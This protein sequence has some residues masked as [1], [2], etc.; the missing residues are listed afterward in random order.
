MKRGVFIFLI[1]LLLVLCPIYSTG[2][3]LNKIS[4]EVLEKVSSND[5]VPVVVEIEKKPSFVAQLVSDAK[6]KKEYVSMELDSDEIASLASDPDVARIT[7]DKTYVLQLSQTVPQINASVAHSTVFKNQN[8][9]GISSTVCVIDTGVNSSHESLAG[10][11]VAEYCYCSAG[12]GCCPNGSVE[13]DSARDGHGHGTHVS[14]IVA[15]G[16]NVIG[17]A[18]GANLAVVKVFSDSGSTTSTDIVNAIAWCVDHASQY[19]ITAISMS[20]G[21]TTQYS[22]YCDSTSPFTSEINRAIANNITVV[23]STGNDYN[24]TGISDPA[25]VQN[26]TA[27]SSV[28]KSD[29]FPGYANRNQL[30]DLVAPG[31]DSSNPVVST[32]YTGGTTS[33]YGTSMAAPHV[34]GAIAILSQYKRLEGS[35]ATPYEMQSYLYDSGLSLHDSSSNRTY[36]RIDVYAA[37]LEA[38]ETNPDLYGADYSPHQVLPDS[39]LTLYINASDNLRLSSVWVEGNFSGNFSNYSMSN[40]AG[41]LYSVTIYSGNFSAGQNLTWRFFTNDSNG[42]LNTTQYY[43]T[44]VANDPSV[45]LSYPANNSYIT[46]LE[47]INFSFIVYDDIDETVNCSFFIDGILNQTNSSVFTNFTTY[48]RANITESSHN[49]SVSCITNR[50]ANDTQTFFFTADA[51]SP[52]FTYVNYSSVVE[53]GYYQNITVNLSEANLDYVNISYDSS[54]ESMSCSNNTCTYSM[55]CSD[56]KTYNVSIVAVDLAGNTNL[57]NFSFF[58]NDTTDKPLIKSV[59]FSSSVSSGSLQSIN[60]LIFDKF[61][62]TDVFIDYGSGN[63]SMNSSSSYNYSYS[64]NVSGCGTLSFKIFAENS[65]NYSSLHTNNFSITDCCG[66]SVCSSTESCSSCSSDCGSCPISTQ[67]SGGSSGGGGG[68]GGEVAEDKATI[69]V[70]SHGE[71]QLSLKVNKKEL[72]VKKIDLELEEDSVSGKVKIE[73]KPTSS[74]PEISERGVY[75]VFTIELVNI[76]EEKISSAEIYFT[77]NSSW[78]SKNSIAPEDVVLTDETLGKLAGAQNRIHR[79]G[80][81]RVQLQGRNSRLLILRSIAQGI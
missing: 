23:A 32:S 30:V 58:A 64:W 13:Q 44:S 48:F 8:L 53:L 21:S 29:T 6:P 51:S 26:T 28:T 19:N 1:L 34:S 18:R 37:L 5:K 56:Y 35:S 14:G 57:T 66:D 42:N 81:K 77:V 33:K 78:L 73:K 36:K 52:V 27:V 2:I 3:N 45:H 10:R 76:N 17:V 12:G 49:W 7:A 59:S 11:V 62:L 41:D 47:N 79:I 43:S 22:S 31:G 67:S 63:I 71:K 75:S 38:D 61:N 72:P 69:L 40:V 80:R 15:A 46:V 70:K 60:A 4:P 50:S 9:T 74:S 39:N 20:L 65:Q 16:G 55:L 25:C 24:Y 54:N 68:G